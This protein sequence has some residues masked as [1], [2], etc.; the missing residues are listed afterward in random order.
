MHI[1]LCF[2]FGLAM[3]SSCLAPPP[4]DVSYVIW[5]FLVFLINAKHVTLI[6]YN[7]RHILFDEER[8]LIYVSLFSK[9]MTRS[10]YQSLMYHSLIRTIRQ[11]RHY[12]NINDTCN[13]LSILVSG[14]MIKTDKLNKKSYVKE[15]SFIDSPEFIMQHSAVGQIF[16]ISFYAETECNVIIWPREILNEQLDNNKKLKNQ[17]LSV[18]GLDVSYK[19][20]L[21]DLLESSTDMNI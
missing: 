20:F 5:F 2:S 19:V 3:L 7:K 16:N 10:E 15:T 9:I 21:L 14:K 12:I 8:E 6:C 11:S 13:N 17:L 1:V 4:V 18:L